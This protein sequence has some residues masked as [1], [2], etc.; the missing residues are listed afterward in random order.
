VAAAQDAM[1]PPRK[2]PAKR[3]FTGL[4][5]SPLAVIEEPEAVVNEPTEAV[6][7]SEPEMASEETTAVFSALCEPPKRGRGRP[8][9]GKAKTPAERK[10]AQRERPEKQKLWKVIEKRVRDSENAD[11]FGRVCNKEGCNDSRHK[12]VQNV[13]YD[14]TAMREDFMRLPLDEARLVAETYEKIWD[15]TGRS[16]REGHTGTKQKQ[17][18]SQRLENISGAVEAREMYGGGKRKNLG[19]GADSDDA[20]VAPD[21]KVSNRISIGQLCDLRERESNFN[22]ASNELLDGEENEPLADTEKG[23][24][25]PIR[26]KVCDQVFEFK[27]QGR[28]HI[29]AEYDLE[30]KQLKLYNAFREA[31]DTNPAYQSIVDD[32]ALWFKSHRHVEFVQHLIRD[33]S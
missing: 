27:A 14:L 31:A 22:Q 23:E 9:T 20:D 12:H 21:R 6:A 3:A 4:A 29:S 7:V 10:Q 30:M 8:S 28:I 11:K 16:S 17:S 5:G 25:K 33:L 32:K 26:C 2:P 18:T 1:L 24:P 13:G 19:A 15:S